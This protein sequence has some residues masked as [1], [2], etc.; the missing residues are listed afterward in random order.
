LWKVDRHFGWPDNW[1]AEAVLLWIR[2]LRIV[3]RAGTVPWY[4]ECYDWRKDWQHPRTAIELAIG[5][6]PC[7]IRRD[8]RRLI[9]RADQTWQSQ[10]LPNPFS[11][12]DLPWWLRGIE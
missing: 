4:D 12:T 8:L 9:S 2:P 6:L 11:R 3:R 1:T 7:R 10:M 5:H